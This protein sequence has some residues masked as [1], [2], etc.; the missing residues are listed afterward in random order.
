MDIWQPGGVRQRTQP[1]AWQSCTAT[2]CPAHVGTL[3]LQ[4]K[5]E[6]V[7]RTQPGVQHRIVSTVLRPPFPPAL[8]QSNLNPPRR[9]Y[10]CQWQPN[11]ELDSRQVIENAPSH[12]RL[13]TRLLA[14]RHDTVTKES[15]SVQAFKCWVLPDEITITSNRPSICVDACYRTTRRLLASASIGLQHFC[16]SQKTYG[17]YMVLPRAVTQGCS[18]LRIIRLHIVRQLGPI[19]T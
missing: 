12:L 18:K 16:L 10:R 9:L 8:T 7:A 4:H 15:L 5:R 2:A 17:H 13:L 14:V 3:R 19:T 6:D 1:A 11:D